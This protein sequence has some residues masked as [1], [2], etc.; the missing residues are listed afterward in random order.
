MSQTNPLE[1]F[2]STA[3]LLLKLHL[4]QADPSAS[5]GESGF[6]DGTFF[7]DVATK[8]E[9]SSKSFPSLEKSL[10]R[11]ASGLRDCEKVALDKPQALAAVA[12]DPFSSRL[13]EASGSDAFTFFRPKG[14]Q[15]M[16][17]HD[18]PVL[19]PFAALKFVRLLNLGGVY[20]LGD[21]A[22]QQL[23]RISGC[24]F[25]SQGQLDAFAREHEERKERDHR[26]IGKNLELF[27]F[28]PLSGQGM[29][30]WLPDGAILRNIIGDYVH[31]RQI[32]HGFSFVST[33]VLGSLE[34]Y[35]ISGHYSHYGED[36]F[37]PVELENETMM[38]R[39]MTCPHHCL[40][41]LSKTRS[42][43]DLPIRLSEDSILH[44]FES[45]GALLGLE[46]VR[47]MTLL[48]NHVFCRPDQIE[49][50]IVNAYGVINEVI[51][52][53][54][55]RIERVDLAL[56]DPK[57]KLKFID[58]EAM[59]RASEAQLE[60]ALR[61]LGV[62]YERQIGDAAFYGPKID[63][64][65]RTALNKIVT[66]STIQLDFSLP[67]KFS[68]TYVD[69]SGQNA[70]CVIIHLGIV[71]TY[72]RFIAT[73]LEQTKGVLPLWLAPR[74]VAIIPVSNE[75]HLPACERLHAFL[76]AN[77]IRCE[78]DARDER[79][80]KKIRD[81]QVRKIPLQIVIGDREAQNPDQ[82]NYR[83]RGSERI[84]SISRDGFVAMIRAANE[85][86][87]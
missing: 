84:V 87:A 43:R 25:G 64:Q 15:T 14:Q 17:W 75:A 78:T 70:R 19:E 12:S 30:L 58:D 47:M 11:L 13:I 40:I 85:A 36:M 52:T 49:S 50:E 27:A 60:D 37:P 71:G 81:A 69:S 68:T 35:K 26:R 10:V 80:S 6:E 51:E 24:G 77:G 67:Q 32:E 23:T 5:F 53:F 57:D 18:A 82:I 79:L 41:Y 33:P 61:K 63:F 54:N 34:L 73:L 39:P 16:V 76:A 55:L 66:C 56:H 59:W 7:L 2:S 86:H 48:D 28:N 46:R 74:Q 31:S 22:N 3:C 42:Y 83:E 21:E 44:R 72:E 65:C 29:A 8:A 20:W 38:L 45:S 9:L 4:L 62:P 1:L